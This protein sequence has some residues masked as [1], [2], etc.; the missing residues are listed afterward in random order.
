[1]INLKA[2]NRCGGD[3]MAEELLGDVELVCL[4]CGH[5]QAMPQPQPAY[6]VRVT[7]RKQ[8]VAHKRAA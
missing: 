1:M 7:T 5:R 8:P 2:C 4:Q 3:M 6:R